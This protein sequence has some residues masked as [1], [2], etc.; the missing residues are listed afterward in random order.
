MPEGV[1]QPS[2]DMAGD[3]QARSAEPSHA[4]A[5]SAVSSEIQETTAAPGSPDDS[6]AADAAAAPLAQAVGAPASW[7]VD[8]T[9]GVDARSPPGAADDAAALVDGLREVQEKLQDARDALNMY[10]ITKADTAQQ[11]DDLLRLP[12]RRPGGPTW[13][14]ALSLQ[15]KLDTGKSPPNEEFDTVIS[16]THKAQTA[17]LR[18]LQRFEDFR[19]RRSRRAEDLI[20]SAVAEAQHMQVKSGTL[21]VSFLLLCVA[22]QPPVQAQPRLGP[23]RRCSA[24]ARLKRCAWML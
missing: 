10:R 18:E 24:R 14:A 2:L 19:F 13:A 22:Q 5:A 8:P 23:G 7:K 11:F 16:E 15:R 9:S 12:R 20:S 21:P 17:M 1:S 6:D 3:E 4:T